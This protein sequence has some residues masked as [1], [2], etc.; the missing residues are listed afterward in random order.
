MFNSSGK[1]ATQRYG[2]RGS[3]RCWVD[4]WSLLWFTFNGRFSEDSGKPWIPYCPK[5]TVRVPTLSTMLNGSFILWDTLKTC[6]RLSRSGKGAWCFAKPT[7]IYFLPHSLSCKCDFATRCN[8]IEYNWLS[9]DLLMARATWQLPSACHCQWAFYKA[10]IPEVAQSLPKPS[11]RYR[12]Y[13]I[14]GS[15]WN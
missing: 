15:L 14:C 2:R 13:K 1:F 12:R 11:F 5:A 4:G 8:G 7:A 9:R 6:T 3:Q 10:H